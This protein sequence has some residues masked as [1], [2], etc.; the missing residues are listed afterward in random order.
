MTIDERT[1]TPGVL[2]E[3]LGARASEGDDRRPDPTIENEAAPTLPKA[4][5]SLEATGLSPSFLMELLVYP[6][7]FYLWK[8][9]VS[10]DSRRELRD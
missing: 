2:V 4:P 8:A 5:E 10:P 1:G 3:P 9:R 7:V 6:V